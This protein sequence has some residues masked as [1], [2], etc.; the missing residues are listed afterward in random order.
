VAILTIS[1]HDQTQDGDA[2]GDSEGASIDLRGERAPFSDKEDV[3]DSATFR[4]SAD[5]YPV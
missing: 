2:Q 3:A 4:Q 1:F 5:S